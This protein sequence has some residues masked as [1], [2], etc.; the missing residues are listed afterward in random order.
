MN[1]VVLGVERVKEFSSVFM[2]KRVGLITNPSGIDSDFRSTI[3]IFTKMGNLKVLF[4]P[5]HGIRGNFQAGEKFESYIDEES[6][7]IVHS[8]YTE[9]RRPTKEMLEDIDVIVFDIQDVGARFYTYIYT[10]AYCMRSA[11]EFNKEFIVLDRPNPVNGEKVEGN[12]LDLEFKSFIGYYPIVQ[13]H[14]LTIG[15][16]ARFFNKEYN[17][18]CALTIIPMLNWQRSMD[19]EDTKLPWVFLSQNIPTNNSSY[20]FLATCVFE[21]TNV[22]EGRGTTKP[23]ELIGAPYINANQL[24]KS[25]NALKLD[26]VYFRPVHFTPHV[27]K[28]EKKLCNGVELYILD[29]KA[30]EPVKTGW[31][32]LYAVRNLY[33]NDFSVNEPYVIGRPHMLDYNV[34]GDFMRKN[35]YNI[36]ELE[37]ILEKDTKE[38][39]SIRQKYLLY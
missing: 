22:S 28:H 19:Y 20:A 32:M 35:I 9:S 30:F 29:R 5:E 36:K 27:S 37:S 33:P 10:M 18:D 23:F 1:K 12:I 3:D 31:N 26:G 25:L 34:G 16:L 8:L 6:G 15:E 7:A 21:G 14:G 39:L 17:I 13:R 2:G 11:K 38:F 24:A 4:A